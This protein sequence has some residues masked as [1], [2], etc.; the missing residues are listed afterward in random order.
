MAKQRIKPVGTQFEVTRNPRAA[1]NAF[2]VDT[3]AVSQG[4]QSMGNAAK[5][6]AVDRARELQL[7]ADLRAYEIAQEIR[8]NPPEDGPWQDVFVERYN[9]Y[10][11]EQ[12]ERVPDLANDEY[13]LWTEQHS[14]REQK[15]LIHDEVQH[16]E[17]QGLA[18]LS[19]NINTMRVHI[20]QTPGRYYDFIPQV[21]GLI[22][23][24]LSGLPADRR[25][26]LER[27]L[28]GQ[29]Y[30]S[31]WTKMIETKE[32]AQQMIAE[33]ESDKHGQFLT[34][35][36][37]ESYLPRSEAAL[38]NFLAVER[39]ERTEAVQAYIN[40]S[41][42]GIE[43]P[44]IDLD[45][46][47]GL[48]FDENTLKR[49]RMQVEATGLV[50][51]EVV[52]RLGRLSVDRMDRLRAELT[53]AWREAAASGDTQ[54]QQFAQMSMQLANDVF[55]NDMRQ[56]LDNWGG[57]ISK[58]DQNFAKREALL[59]EQIARIARL[60]L[61][62]NADKEEI[63]AQIDAARQAYAANIAVADSMAR[64][65]GM[66]PNG[67]KRPALSNDFLNTF[68][69]GLQESQRD[70]EVFTQTVAALIHTGGSNWPRLARE[71]WGPQGEKMPNAQE[72]NAVVMAGTEIGE[73]GIPSVTRN[74]R[75]AMVAY[76]Q[77]DT[78]KKQN[79]LGRAEKMDPIR[80]AVHE[81]IGGLVQ[82]FAGEDPEGNMGK[83]IAEVGARYVAHMHYTRGIDIE[84][85]AQQFGQMVDRYEIFDGRLRVPKTYVRDSTRQVM[86]DLSGNGSN[87]M[88]KELLN[89]LAEGSP[90]MAALRERSPDFYE[91]IQFSFQNARDE[92]GMMFFYGDSITGSPIT[93]K[94]NRPIVVPWQV[95]NTASADADEMNRMRRVEMFGPDEEPNLLR[96]VGGGLE[97]GLGDKKSVKRYGDYLRNLLEGKDPDVTNLYGYPTDASGQE[98]RRE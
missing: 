67:E 19:E 79:D 47:E 87:P 61:D 97:F 4:I 93:D 32:G 96:D 6:I 20:A 51:D 7:E 70:P 71:I 66:L 90:E 21:Q 45:S 44:P 28:V 85:A 46:L 84:T 42:A 37:R 74:G 95:L 2:T 78:I 22:E 24:R 81:K 82:T 38:D 88:R 58:H 39:G 25:R 11:A 57:W 15:R 1:L 30:D 10:V 91:D 64:D 9:E 27:Q 18:N 33:L 77:W 86:Q 56:R 26:A 60:N 36:Q 16:Q 13:A 35:D 89:V 48:G 43:S 41:M 53:G 34:Q 65:K 94:F 50:Q 23:S 73:S 8:E 76:A 63:A 75:E 98:K 92:S 31:Y 59:G 49:L 62:P 80:A 72:L 14:V 12:A 17:T 40:T 29:L 5:K 52:K 69:A 83:A 68:R 55:E 3:R 54:V